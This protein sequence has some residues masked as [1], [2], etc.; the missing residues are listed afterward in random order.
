MDQGI[1][2]VQDLALSEEMEEVRLIV[3]T[4]TPTPQAQ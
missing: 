3:L 1:D 4:A 2:F